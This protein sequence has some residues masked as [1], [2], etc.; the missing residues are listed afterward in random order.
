ML[1][2]TWD[3]V[4]TEGFQPTLTEDTL[5]EAIKRC[6]NS[7]TKSYRYV[8]PTQLIAKLANESLDCR[9]LQATRGGPGAFDARSVCHK[10]VVKFD[11]DNEEVLGGSP[12][13]YVNNPLR[14]P[15]VTAQYRVQ[16]KDK[17][18][19]DDLCSI[20][21][22]VERE[23]SSQFTE[24]VLEQTLF[25]I[26]NRLSQIKISYPVPNRISY[27]QA[28]KLIED[29]LAT[30]S[31]GDRPQA[32]ASALLLT[33]GEKF[34]LFKEIRRSKVTAA[35]ASTGLVADIE[36][37]DFTG[38]ILAVEVRDKELTIDQVKGKLRRARSLG[39]SELLFLVQRGILQ[40]DKSEISR[41]IEREFSSGQNIYILPLTTFTSSLFVLLREDGRREFLTAVGNTLNKYG[42]AIQHRR[43]WAELLSNL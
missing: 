24:I 8:L 43:A 29:F 26:F 21:D 25:E 9:C 37:L 31:L 14:V 20:L 38:S 1:S 10:V 6:V 13:P 28:N 19:W 27:E 32:I 39:V 3:K 34:K 35:D 7:K 42:S 12:E 41:L 40:T 11:K 2:K 30:P 18:G 15:E 5:C 17:E 16:Q 36:C 23:Q 33:I 4:S 22:R